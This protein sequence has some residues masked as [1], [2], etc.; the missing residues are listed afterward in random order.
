MSSFLNTPNSLLLRTDFSDDSAWA[1]LVEKLEADGLDLRGLLE[2]V[3]DPS[4]N[5]FSTDDIARLF[6]ADEAQ[7][8]VEEQGF[9]IVADFRTFTDELST[10]MVVNLLDT[11]NYGGNDRIGRK[12]RIP[13]E[14][15]WDVVANIPIGNVTFDEF[16]EEYDEDGFRR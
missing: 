1:T 7:G 12:F 2:Y 10:V 13:V 4:H 6:E 11:T 3:S 15:V 16:A 14:D 5:G 9:V 8:F